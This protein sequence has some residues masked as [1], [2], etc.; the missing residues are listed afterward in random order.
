VKP[1]QL[2]YVR[3]GT[4]GPEQPERGRGVTVR[5]RHGVEGRPIRL[6]AFPGETPVFDF[7]TMK[8]KKNYAGFLF[9]VDHWHVKGFEVTGMKQVEGGFVVGFLAK[10]CHHCVFESI[11]SHDHDGIGFYL[12]GD[13]NH[14]LILNSDFH[15][16]YDKDTKGYS[17]GHADGCHMRV[18]HKGHVN[19]I[20]GCRLWWNSDDGL[21]LWQNEGI[22]HIENCWAFWNGYVRGTF[23]LAADGNGFK[24]GKTVMDPDPTPQRYVRNCVAYANKT[25]GF[26]QNNGKI[27]MVFYNNTAYKNGDW[28]FWTSKHGLVD[29][30]RNNIALGNYARRER[31]VEMYLGDEDDDE[32]NTWNGIAAREADFASV[33][34]TGIDGPR[35]ADGSLPALTF[36]KLRRTSRL[37]DRG[38]DVGLPFGGRAP[39][40]G[41]YEY[42]VPEPKPEPA[43]R[44]DTRAAATRAVDPLA[45]ARDALRK[46]AFGEAADLARSAKDADETAQTTL[47][48][49][50]EAGTRLRTAVIGSVADVKPTLRLPFGRTLAHARVVGATESGLVVNVRGNRGP[51]LWQQLSPLQFYRLA[52]RTTD[53]QKSLADYCHATGLDSQ[54]L[55]HRTPAH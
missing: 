12:G 3:G 49:G 15:H 25:R 20:R 55:A 10:S 37:I 31:T 19:T 44:D 5:D 28:G 48:A 16:C 4:Y 23:D 17:G 40:L 11:D 29:V 35:Q 8:S 34:H 30:L 24:L 46:G 14:N 36:L 22:V 27:R 47:V 26:D 21:D 1:G 41:A 18:E 43:E 9:T 42:G 53:D 39:D 13:S 32:H 6:W 38:V 54:A 7:S 50:A 33:D 51:M 52:V 45:K 2:I